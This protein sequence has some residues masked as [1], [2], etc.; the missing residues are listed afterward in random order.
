MDPEM[1]QTLASNP[2]AAREHLQAMIAEQSA[3]D[4]RIGMLMKMLEQQAPGPDAAPP[5]DARADRVRERVR[6]MRAELSILRRRNADLAAALGACQM[7]WGVDDRCPDCAGAGAPGWS[8][9][10]PDL[11]DDLVAPA[12]ERH[13]RKPAADP[14]PRSAT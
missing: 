13:A 7:C 4:P 8:K 5:R 6:E 2:A 1:L 14:K 9:P 11:Y 12:I 3:R 10:D